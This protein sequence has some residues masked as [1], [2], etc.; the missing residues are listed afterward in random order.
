MRSSLALSLSCSVLLLA[1]VARGG[2]QSP[3]V[4]VSI[5][6][7]RT[8]AGGGL[9]EA[10]WRYADAQIVDAENTVGGGVVRTHD[11]RP[12]PGTAEFDA[13]SWEAIGADSLERRRTGGRLAFGWYRLEFTIP[14]SIGGESTA[15]DGVVL[16]LTIDDYAEVWV[17]GQ[18]PKVLGSTPQLAGGWNKPMR[19]LVRPSAK[20]GERVSVAIFAA[21]GPLSDPPENFVWVRSATLDFYK[22]GVLNP[23]KPVNATVSRVAPGIDTILPP[24]TVVEKLAEG[25]SFIEGPVWVP[26]SESARYGGGGRGDY[27]LFSDPNK[28]V[29]HRWDPVTGDVSIYRTKSGYTGVDIGRYHQP[30]SNGLTLDPQGRLTICE[31]G[32]RRVTRLEPNGSITV[33]ADSYQGKR[34]NSPN[35]LVYRSD[36]VL[37][38]TDPPFGLPG[39][40]NDPAKELPTSG[41]FAVVHGQVRQVSTELA[42]PNGLAFSPDE[43][44]LYV[45]NW[46]ESRKVV[47]R[48]AVGSDGM[49]SDPTVFFDMTNVKGE[50]ALDG[51]KVDAAGNVYVSG[52]GGVWI[53]SAEGKHL[54]TLTL[55]ELPANFA[56]GDADGKTLYMAARTGL[57][58]VRVGVEGIRPR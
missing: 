16:E 53:I 12:K 6:D 8:T 2:E 33:L 5:V 1:G 49:L 37:Y 31:H 47:M 42:A 26:A 41:I 9:V 44:Y 13:A 36:G 56:F 22:P 28:N 35:D 48:F 4:P 10:S 14:S 3:P 19:V 20:P 18:L 24:G 23:G 39:V 40:F 43:K 54:G 45:D 32:N 17:D 57:Y 38:F 58:R 52:P 7:L 50:I 21:N 25:F 30:G 11:I 15:G 46:E 27:L 34:L 29:I 55:P 51:L